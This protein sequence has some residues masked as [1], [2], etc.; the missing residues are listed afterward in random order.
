[1]IKSLKQENLHPI[2]MYSFLVGALCHT[3]TTRHEQGKE[4]SK[5]H[6]NFIKIDM[7]QRID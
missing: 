3:D 1:M 4:D 6:P 7:N 5:A 2:I